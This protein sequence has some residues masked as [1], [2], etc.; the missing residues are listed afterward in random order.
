MIL[1]ILTE[2]MSWWGRKQNKRMKKD[3]DSQIEALESDN[4]NSNSEK[5]ND[6]RKL[7]KQLDDS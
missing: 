2:L 7:R 1:T 5:L 6:L 3:V 4:A